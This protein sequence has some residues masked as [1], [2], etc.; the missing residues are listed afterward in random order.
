MQDV[1]VIVPIYNEELLMNRCITSIVNQTHGELEILLID[2]GST[3]NSLVIC[4]EWAK[5]DARIQVIHKENEGLG[6]TRNLGI[7][8]A[9]NEIITFVDADDW[10]DK[11]FVELLLDKMNQADTELSVCNMF[12]WD[13]KKSEQVLSKIRFENDVVD[14]KT[15]PSVMNRVRTFAWGKLWKKH[16]FTNDLLFPAWT[17]ED[18]ASI[19]L[20]AY[21]AKK[22]GYVNRGLY[23]Y[24][25]NQP[26]SLSAQGENI[27]DIGKSLH[28]LWKRAAAY[29]LSEK[30]QLEIKKIMLSQVR[31]AYQRWGEY[32]TYHGSLER[33]SSS[34]AAY[35]P[36]F[37]GYESLTFAK[38]GD[39]GFDR[40]L[41]LVAYSEERIM[42]DGALR[43]DLNRFSSPKQEAEVWRIAEYIMEQM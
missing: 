25:R 3:D 39:A 24:W 20:L 9:K 13:S 36:C 8:M 21:K 16:L 22:I 42:E 41:A 27:P 43:F 30:Q 17:F 12:Y 7:S 15:E 26:D 18:I 1:T 28:L 14:V 5:K 4:R 29:P 34:L 37:R 35:Y 38:T 33:L 6:P 32:K 31:M 2:D 11:R 23:H 19:P 40:A 10:L